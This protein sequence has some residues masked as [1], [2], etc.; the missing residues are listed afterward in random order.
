[1]SLKCVGFALLLCGLAATNV[2]ADDHSVVLVSTPPRSVNVGGSFPLTLSLLESVRNDLQINVSCPGNCTVFPSIVEFANGTIDQTVIVTGTTMGLI[3]LSFAGLGCDAPRYTMPNIVNVY[4]TEPVY[5]NLTQDS[6]SLSLRVSVATPP[7]EALSITALL[8]GYPSSGVSFGAGSLAA[9]AREATIYGSFSSQVRPTG[10]VNITLSFTG[11]QASFFSADILQTAIIGVIQVSTYNTSIH[12]QATVSLSSNYGYNYNAYGSLQLIVSCSS[13]LTTA[14]CGPRVLDVSSTG[15]ALSQVTVFAGNR[16]G[17]VHVGFQLV[18]AAS[19]FFTVDPVIIN[20]QAPVSVNLPKVVPASDSTVFNVSL[21]SPVAKGLTISLQ[22]N[23]QKARVEPASVTLREGELGAIFT[24]I[25]TADTSQIQISTVLSGAD[26]TLF[27]APYSSNVDVREFIYFDE[28]PTEVEYVRSYSAPRVSIVARTKNPARSRFTLNMYAPPSLSHTSLDWSEGAT[29]MT[30][31]V[32]ANAP[33]RQQG[34]A[35]FSLSNQDTSTYFLTKSQWQFLVR[36]RLQVAAWDV[37]PVINKGITSSIAY[38]YVQ[39]SYGTAKIDVSVSL[40]GPAASTAVL[41]D[42]DAAFSCPGGS[43]G[44]TKPVSIALGEVSDD[45]NVHYSLSGDDAKYFYPLPSQVVSVAGPIEVVR[46][47]DK[48][49]AGLRTPITVRLHGLV[50]SALNV[51]VFTN[52]PNVTVSP[53]VVTVTPNTSK[54]FTVTLYANGIPDNSQFFLGV[55]CTGADCA[56]HQTPDH[57]SLMYNLQY[58][59][60]VRSVPPV[61]AKDTL[62]SDLV[63]DLGG[64]VPHDLSISVYSSYGTFTPQTMAVQAGAKWTSFKGKWSAAGPATMVYQL[65]GTDKNLFLLP[66]PNQLIVQDSL[67]VADVPFML[68]SSTVSNPITIK[69]SSTNPSLKDLQIRIVLSGDIA[70][71]C[72]VEPA[73]LRLRPN[74]ASHTFTLFAGPSGGDLTVSFELSGVDAGLF[75]VPQPVKI[76]VTGGSF[77]KFLTT[78]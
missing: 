41:V 24:L 3:S 58:A 19:P 54:D 18:G 68:E 26:A 16:N 21:A 59:M 32:S 75:Q 71:G 8:N 23:Q 14:S 78:Y 63:I 36:E 35:S 25:T 10:P 76:T 69:T 4:C 70:A 38:A 37:V 43:S 31:N 74:Y 56:Y 33:Y 20:V 60:K 12:S 46:E 22:V 28:M 62:T 39:G 2:V 34:S 27:A 66:S 42:A 6:R 57:W 11:P 5:V 65:G 61:I 53:T 45:L 50:S 9:N 47:S 29:S 40:W 51:T 17:Q 15:G 52:S 77:S 67:I 73:V 72:Q 64:A 55:N 7:T 48:L 1:M 44:C 30:V 49:V 13:F